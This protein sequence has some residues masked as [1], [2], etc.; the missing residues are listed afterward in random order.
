MRPPPAAKPDEHGQRHPLR[1]S[2]GCQNYQLFGGGILRSQEEQ[3]ALEWAAGHGVLVVAAA[4]N[5]GLNSDFFHFYPADYDLTNIL[6]VGA[7]DRK[8]Q[9]LAIS[10]FGKSTVDISAPGKN[11]YSTLP[12]GEHGFMTGTSQ[13]TAFVSGISALIMSHQPELRKPER[14]IHHLLGQTRRLPQLRG[15]SRSEAVAD[16]SRALGPGAKPAIET[17]FAADNN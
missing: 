11:I 15:L 2:Y 16:A 5:E 1:G 10:N 8:S 12:G 9:P 17:V 14:L 6:S 3:S 7:V 13:A 4:G